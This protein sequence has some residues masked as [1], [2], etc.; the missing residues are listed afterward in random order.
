MDT[1][2]TV[3]SALNT[4]EVEAPPVL[5]KENENS[6]RKFLTSFAVRM[7]IFLCFSLSA[8]VLF[9]VLGYYN[10]RNLY[11]VK[12]HKPSVAN[13]PVV[14]TAPSESDSTGNDEVER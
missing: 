5:E 3:R 6:C 7:T 13:L 12:N 8:T 14:L 2:N 4:P 9:G 1:R 10:V 11:D